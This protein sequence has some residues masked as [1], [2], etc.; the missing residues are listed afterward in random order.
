MP[1]SEADFTDGVATLN[2]GLTIPSD[3]TDS[4]VQGFVLKN[5]TGIIPVDTPFT[6]KK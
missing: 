2:I 6:T 1:F 4:Y 5:L 3:I